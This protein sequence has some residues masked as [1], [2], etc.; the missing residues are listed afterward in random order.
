MHHTLLEEACP[1]ALSCSAS[2]CGFARTL[3]LRT[4]LNHH[5]WIIFSQHLVILLYMCIS[6]LLTKL[7]RF[8]AEADVASLSQDL[9]QCIVQKM[10]QELANRPQ[11]LSTIRC[12]VG[13]TIAD[14]F[15]SCF[16][17]QLAYTG[18]CFPDG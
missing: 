6:L 15:P 2:T 9:F 17:T 4:S 3:L 1:A 18:G 7:H 5:S 16:M 10:S 13:Q 8:I 14:F 12:K 11:W